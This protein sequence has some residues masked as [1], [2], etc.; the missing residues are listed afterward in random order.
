V[1]FRRGAGLLVRKS[2]FD[3]I[4][5]YTC[6]AARWGDEHVKLFHARF[7]IGDRQR[8]EENVLTW[9]GKESTDAERNG[10][11]LV[12]T[13]VVEQSLDIDFDAMVTD[14][15]PIDLIIQRAGRLHRHRER[16][17]G[18]VMT[19]TLLILSPPPVEDPERDWFTRVFPERGKYTRNTGSS[20]SPHAC[21]RQGTDRDARRCSAADLE[22]VLRQGAGIC[23]RSPQVWEIQAD[24]RTGGTQRCADQKRIAAAAGYA[25]LHGQWEDRRE[26]TR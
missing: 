21:L 15:A 20:G 17:N 10:K 13:Q 25:D 3:A 23:S 11:I 9:F 16:R 19:P 6:L 22:G 2:V 4:E 14:L 5:A 8:I 24:G 12:A 18:P 1:L 7:T 26:P